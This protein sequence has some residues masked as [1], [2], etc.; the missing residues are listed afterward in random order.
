MAVWPGDSRQPQSDIADSLGAIRTVGNFVA[1]PIKNTSSGELVEVEPSEALF[2]FFFVQPAKLAAKRK[3]LDHKLKR[4]GKP[5][6]K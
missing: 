2:D 6:L 4:A 5:H 1:H 3:M